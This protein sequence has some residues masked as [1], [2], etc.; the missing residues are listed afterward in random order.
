M[1]TYEDCLGMTDLTQEEVDAISEHEHC[2]AIIA[3]ALGNYLVAAFK[4]APLGVILGL[5]DVLGTAQEIQSDSFR[6]LEPFTVTG[7]LFLA[8]SIPAA[9]FARFLERRY[10]FQRD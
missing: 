6:D 2:P 1:L 4:D 5:T 10:G 7:V 3:L 8:V 9:G